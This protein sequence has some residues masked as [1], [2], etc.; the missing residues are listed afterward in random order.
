M[1][2]ENQGISMFG[3]TAFHMVWE[4]VCADVFGNK[5]NVNIGKIQLNVPLAAGYDEKWKLID[6]I[7]KPK[8]CGADT[9]QEARETLI[10]DLI[11]INQYDGQDWF[12]IF[13]AKYYLLQLEKGR[14]LRG[15]PGIGDVT[16][17]YLY[18]LA[19]KKFIADHNIA[20]V[21]NCFLMPTEGKE[22]VV[23]GAAKLEMLSELGLEDIQIRLI[24]AD[25]LFAYYLSRKRIDIQTLRL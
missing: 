1:L 12:I 23:K 25:M 19:Y 4:R 2:E 6:L 14:M 5:L 8:W 21:R 9:V 15:N 18:Q 7:E 24:P 10:P 17:Q 11:S 22:I 3:T 13:D 20:V 16:K